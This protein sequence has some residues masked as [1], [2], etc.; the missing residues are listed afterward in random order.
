MLVF[1]SSLYQNRFQPMN[2]LIMIMMMEVIAKTKIY[3]IFFFASPCFF[4]ITL[5]FSRFITTS[6]TVLPFDNFPVIFTRFGSENGYP[7]KT[8]YLQIVFPPP[9]AVQLISA[10]RADGV[11]EMKKASSDSL[12]YKVILLSFSRVRRL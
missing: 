7:F 12:S 5:T 11:L 3:Y 9:T 10:V 1:L 4:D 2:S 6:S 8:W